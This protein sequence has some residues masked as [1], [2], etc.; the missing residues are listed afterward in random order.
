MAGPG[1]EAGYPDIGL[2]VNEHTE[3]K[4]KKKLLGF[5]PVLFSPLKPS[6]PGS[7]LN[8]AAGWGFQWVSHNVGSDYR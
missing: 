4:K 7:H 5:F 1:R 8:G 2:H 3:S 6:G